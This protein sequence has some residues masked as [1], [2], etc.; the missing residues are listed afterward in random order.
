[1]IKDYIDKKTN[2]KMYEIV[3]EYIGKNPLTGKEKRIKK[4]GF[5]TKKEAELHVAK[6]KL[7]FETKHSVLPNNI[8]F[9][10]LWDLWY[11]SRR[12]KVSEKTIYT[13]NNQK[14]KY[15]MP[16]FGHLQVKKIHTALIQDY[17]NNTLAPLYSEATMNQTRTYLK[18][19]LEYAVDLDLL[20]KNPC[21]KVKVPKK[22]KKEATFLEKEELNMFLE[23]AKNKLKKIYYVYIRLL[24]MTGARRGEIGALLWSDIDFKNKTININKTISQDKTGTKIYGKKTKTLSS[25][26]IVTVDDLTMELLCELKNEQKILS[27]HVFTITNYTHVYRQVKQCAKEIGIEELRVHDLRHTH[28]TLLLEAGVAIKVVQE[29]LG[30]SNINTTLNLYAKVTKNQRN[31]VVSSFLEHIS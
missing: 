4:K 19:A 15:I 20:I 17:F 29:R 10:K 24:A 30:H 27:I 23:V 31:N 5:K 25:K 3:G 21:K 16:F 13:I 7:E 8:T 12:F 2:K 18:S 22:D 6:A 26:R 14:N 11:E 1:M 9:E 28:T